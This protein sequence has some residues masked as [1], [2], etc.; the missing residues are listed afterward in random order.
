MPR[1][2]KVNLQKTKDEGKFL[3]PTENKNQDY[4]KQNKGLNVHKLLIR[5]YS[6]KDRERIFNVPKEQN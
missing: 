2:I 6:L 3:K 1:Y 4:I 5:K